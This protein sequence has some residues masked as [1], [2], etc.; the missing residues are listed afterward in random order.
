MTCPGS[1][2][3]GMARCFWLC[4][5]DSESLTSGCPFPYPGDRAARSRPGTSDHPQAERLWAHPAHA[6]RASCT[7]ITPLGLT[8]YLA[9]HRFPMLFNSLAAPS[10]SPVTF[11]LFPISLQM[12]SLANDFKAAVCLNPQSF[13]LAT[14]HPPAL[15]S[16][17][18]QSLRVS[19]TRPPFRCMGICD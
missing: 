16:G 1:T 4:K 13:V 14:N 18:E 15:T 12:S 9:S 11:P 3:N 6:P 2:T 7:K 5:R 17:F 19:G 8:D 10:L